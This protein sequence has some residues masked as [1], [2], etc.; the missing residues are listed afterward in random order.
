MREPRTWPYPVIFAGTVLA[1]IGFMVWVFTRPATPPAI[2]A[3]VPVQDMSRWQRVELECD[4]QVAILMST[5]DVVEMERA[6]FLIRW[7][8]CSIGRRLPRP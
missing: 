2:A 1:M 8:D 6:Q 7:F 4:R 3:G 5:K